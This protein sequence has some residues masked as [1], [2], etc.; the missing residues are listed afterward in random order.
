[1]CL[2]AKQSANNP[3]QLQPCA[4]TTQP[5]Q[6]WLFNDNG[7]F[8]GT[9]D[10]SKPDNFCFAVDGTQPGSQVI[11]RPCNQGTG[12]TPDAL[13][14]AGAAGASS[15]QLVNLN[16]FG[17]C[18]DVPE[19]DVTKRFL[20]AWPCKQAPDPADIGWNQKWKLPTIASNAKSAVGPILT[21]DDQGRR[22]CLRS[23][24]TTAASQYVTVQQCPTNLAQAPTWTVYGD[25]GD[26]LTRYHIKDSAGLCLSP[27]DPNAT[28]PD[29]YT[30][31][32]GYQ[33]SKIV[34]ADCGRSTLQMWN[35]PALGAAVE[36]ISER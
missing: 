34:V 3:V 22:W 7:N 25:T 15:Q 16:Q 17:R 35:A 13:V 14:G 18:L 28:P 23:P 10:G 6:Q 4:T 12:L 36:D 32:N 2:E 30:D 19:F 33:I 27:T 24:A 20:I 5:Q 29:F 9:K 31:T 1:M 8:Q 11:T 26:D 21:T